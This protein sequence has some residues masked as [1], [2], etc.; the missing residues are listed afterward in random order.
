[1][2]GKKVRRQY[3][4]DHARTRHR[5]DF[6]RRR[7]MKL[8]THHAHD[9][10]LRGVS[11]DGQFYTGRNAAEFYR[12]FPATRVTERIEIASLHDFRKLRQQIITSARISMTNPHGHTFL[13]AEHQERKRQRLPPERM[14]SVRIAYMGSNAVFTRRLL[15]QL[16]AIGLVGSIAA[17]LF[18]AQKAS[19]R[20]KQYRGDYVD[21]AYD[22]KGD[23]LKRLCDLLI[24]Q[25]ELTWGWGI[26]DDMDEFGPRHVLY[27]D[28]PRGQASFHSLRRYTGPD[29]GGTWDGKHESEGNI[30][31][32]T[33]RVLRTGT[34]TKLTRHTP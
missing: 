7:S 25:N 11:E 22:R 28:L 10:C 17:Q 29:Y 1:M 19:G 9:G 30:I 6:L 14:S 15:R 2:K 18:R 24:S 16:E 33:E 32:F 13:A 12:T 4:N 3:E 23:S 8:F 31:D 26:D 20:A 5:A 21:Y 34:N 27:I